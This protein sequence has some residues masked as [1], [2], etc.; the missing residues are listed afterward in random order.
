[1]DL[2]FWVTALAIVILVWC[3]LV[4]VLVVVGRVLLARELAA[5]VPNLVR[6]FGGLMRDR[7]VGLAPKIALGLG[8]LWLASPID[9]IPD[10]IPLVGSLDDAIVAALVLRFVFA[11]T[12][13]TIVREHWQGDPR[14]LERIT[15]LV[16]LGRRTRPPA[17]P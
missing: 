14:T 15:R 16:L 9:L 8:S 5:L 10:F 13:P 4:I 12:D 7:R 3:A 11:T 2:T 1:M 17:L 6:L